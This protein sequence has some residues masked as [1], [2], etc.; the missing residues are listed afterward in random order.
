MSDFIHLNESATKLAALYAA[1][2]PDGYE[3]ATDK[4]VPPADRSEDCR[5]LLD[6]IQF[7]STALQGV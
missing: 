4:P 1:A 6:L 7:Y 2:Y 5:Y 3:Y